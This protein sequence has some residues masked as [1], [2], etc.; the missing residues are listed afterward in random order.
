MISS[1]IFRK[2]H[3]D[4]LGNQNVYVNPAINNNH[5]NGDGF[6][7]RHRNAMFTWRKSL[8]TMADM[9]FRWPASANPTEATGPPWSQVTVLVDSLREPNPDAVAFDQPL[10]MTWDDGLDDGL[11]RC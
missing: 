1:G 6:M 5:R 7:Y 4:S 2:A 3:P 8:V 9:V 10:G 11:D